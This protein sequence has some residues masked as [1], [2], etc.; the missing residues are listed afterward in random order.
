LGTSLD[1][2]REVAES[3]DETIFVKALYQIR[4]VGDRVVQEIT[5]TKAQLAKQFHTYGFDIGK[6]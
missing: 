6:N 2:L 5:N 4:S 1:V 3:N